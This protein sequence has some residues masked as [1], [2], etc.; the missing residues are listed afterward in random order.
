[1]SST[2]LQYRNMKG[3]TELYSAE[4]RK[5]GVK[6]WRFDLWVK[7]ELIEKLLTILCTKSWKV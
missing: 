1:M 3:V 6:K 5:R 2:F 4:V 7:K